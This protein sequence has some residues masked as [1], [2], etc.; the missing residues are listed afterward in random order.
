MF[1]QY[2]KALDQGDIDGMAALVS[3]DFR[4]EGAGLDGIGKHGFMAA[5]KAQLDAFR[6]TP[7]T[8]PM[9]ARMRTWSTL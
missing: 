8:R 5:M 1:R 3:D 4:L 2:T 6:T 9:S 7:R